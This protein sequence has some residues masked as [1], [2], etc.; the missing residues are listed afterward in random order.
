MAKFESDHLTINE[1]FN[2]GFFNFDDEAMEFKMLRT[3]IEVQF[4][5]RNIRKWNILEREA[6][7]A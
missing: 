7:V 3:I 5:K 6:L 4:Y 1:G 2:L